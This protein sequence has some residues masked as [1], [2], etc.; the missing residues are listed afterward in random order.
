MSITVT[1]N[2]QEEHV[3]LWK[4]G[5]LINLAP[6][7]AEYADSNGVHKSLAAGINDSGQVL[8]NSNVYYPEIPSTPPDCLPTIRFEKSR[9]LVWQN[10]KLTQLASK[11]IFFN[12]RQS[13][14]GF[15]PCY[16]PVKT[17]AFG[18]ATYINNSGMIAGSGAFQKEADG[19][20]SITTVLWLSGTSI[21]FNPRR[22]FDH[23]IGEKVNALG[24]VVTLYYGMQPGFSGEVT[25]LLSTNGS[26]FEAIPVPVGWGLH[27]NTIDINNKGQ[28]VGSTN[29]TGPFYPAFNL[30]YIYQDGIATDLNT[31]I[32][33]NS[34]WK[35]S[36]AYTINEA[37]QIL[38]AGNLGYA[39]LTP[40]VHAPCDA[41]QD[42]KI[43]KTDL[44]LIYAANR[45]ANPA[46]D[47]D[48]D[49]LVTIRDLRKCVL[50]CSKAN[51]EP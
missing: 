3:F 49:G 7:G 40:T 50:Q 30:T 33:A 11:E 16:A 45:T 10:G 23:T 5:H 48:A 20:G 18:T 46:Y 25:H 13:M 42:G 47:I 6:A 4:N 8:L 51:C 26:S 37:G 21:Q 44:S 35:L 9:P 38:V 2:P 36:S 29:S 34:G 15:P 19:A 22:F 12:D 32:P 24:Q 28:V 17:V 1:G 14:Y 39:L 27:N 41:N 31:L 43:N